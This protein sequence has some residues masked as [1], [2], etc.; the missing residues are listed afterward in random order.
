LPRHPLP[1][2]PL[3]TGTMTIHADGTT[4]DRTGFLQEGIG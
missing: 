1:G 4:T 3:V 2:T